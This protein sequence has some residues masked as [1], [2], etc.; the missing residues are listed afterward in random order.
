MVLVMAFI[1][2]I[3]EQI[4]QAELA[5][6]FFCISEINLAPVS[7]SPIHIYSDS[8]AAINAI[9]SYKIE[10][11]L[12]MDCIQALNLIAANRELTLIWCPAHSNIEGNDRADALARVGTQQMAFGPEP[13]FPITEKRCRTICKLWLQEKMI[14]RWR[15]TDKCSHTKHFIISPEVKLTNQL[16]TFSKLKLSFTIGML[17]GHIRLNEYLKRIGVRDDPDCDYCGRDSE[18]AIHFL[19]N[20]PQL[21]QIRKEIYGYSF[22][23]P[24]EAISAGLSKIFSFAHRSGRFPITESYPTTSQTLQRQGGGNATINV[25]LPNR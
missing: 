6:I 14:A 5:A 2:Q 1:M 19:C 25:V 3:L 10:S 22:L 15:N 7:T 11:K 20:C 21:S 8:L 4:T 24:S 13:F 16:L 17:T 18:S 9:S 12:V 23:T